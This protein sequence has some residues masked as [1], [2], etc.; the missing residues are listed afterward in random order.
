MISAVLLLL[1]PVF[2]FG[3]EVVITELPANSEYM[4]GQAGK[5]CREACEAVG[6]TCN[7]DARLAVSSQAMVENAF[8]TG[9]GIDCDRVRE[10]TKGPYYYRSSKGQ[11]WCYYK[12]V[13]A[14]DYDCDIRQQFGQHLCV[15]DTPGTKTCVHP[16]EEHELE[17]NADGFIA[18]LNQCHFDV[19]SDCAC[20]EQCQQDEYHL[21]FEWKEGEAPNC[22]CYV[23]NA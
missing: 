22:C 7:I 19:A 15:C 14:E 6:K 17:V 1:L 4:L 8:K 21:S 18:E 13:N 10:D 12:S 11:N 16:E 5:S 3:G 23:Q 20:M 2:C 9:L